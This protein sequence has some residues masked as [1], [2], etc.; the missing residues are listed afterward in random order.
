MAG[1]SLEYD[2]RELKK[3]FMQMRGFFPEVSA[4]LMGYIGS[5][6]KPL[7]KTQFL[8]G[9][10]INLK[11][12]PKDVLGH[13]TISYSIGKKAKYVRFSSYVLNLFERG[14]TLRSGRKE[15]GHYVMTRKFKTFMLSNL[16]RFGNEFDSKI[17]QPRVNKL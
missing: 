16:D 10:E 5:K 14:R 8:S 6:G 9:Q 12:Y 15:K 4:Q 11:A 13:P 3:F 2:D 1:L 7:L 17:L